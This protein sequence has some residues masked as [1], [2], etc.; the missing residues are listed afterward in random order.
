MGG[1]IVPYTIPQAAFWKLAQALPGDILNFVKV[2]VDE[3]QVMARQ[4]NA[5]CTEASIEPAV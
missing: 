1:F 3:A 2:T 5:I 4:L